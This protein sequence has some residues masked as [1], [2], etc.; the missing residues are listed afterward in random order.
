[1]KKTISFLALCMIITGFYSCKKIV[2]KGDI[3]I[4]N[5]TVTG[6]NS[7]SV[8]MEATVHVQVSQQYS[9][10]VRAQENLMPYIETVVEG[11]RLVVKLKNNYVLGRHEEISVTIEAPAVSSLDVSG[12]GDIFVTRPLVSDNF[13]M[14]ISGSGGIRVDT[15]SVT[16]LES[17]I[18]GSGNIY[19][20]TGISSRSDV[21]ISGS[22][23]TDII[24]VASD[25]VYANISGSGNIYCYA[26]SYLKAVISGSGNIYYLGTPTVDAQVSGSGSVIHL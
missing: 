2:G 10:Q 26:G 17:M 9:M 13:V 12:S 6:Y 21:T 23:T 18:S 16:N 3:I 14:T 22:G 7:V 5:R 4:E 8:A 1:M 15:V 19:V 25:K 20:A 24:G 11:T